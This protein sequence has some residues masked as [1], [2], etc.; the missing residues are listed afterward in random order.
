MYDL[1]ARD[2]LFGGEPVCKKRECE[3]RRGRLLLVAPIITI[4]YF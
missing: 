3:G 1:L 4:F 2:H